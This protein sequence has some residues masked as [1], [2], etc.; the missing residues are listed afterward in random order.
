MEDEYTLA[1]SPYIDKTR[2]IEK[3]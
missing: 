1:R 2:W 3:L